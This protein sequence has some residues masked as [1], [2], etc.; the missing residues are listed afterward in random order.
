MKLILII[1]LISWNLIVFFAYLLDKWTAKRKYWRISEKTL[2]LMTIFSGAFGAF[3][4]AYL[5][6]H[7]IRK[8]Y[9]QLSWYLG[10]LIDLFLIFLILN[11][12]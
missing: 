12:T 4:A 10:M 5:V 7:K 9:F 11:Y 8:W 1:L 2:L 6:R 3:I